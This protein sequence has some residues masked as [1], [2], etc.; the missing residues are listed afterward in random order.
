MYYVVRYRR[1][2][3]RENLI[4]S[5]PEKSTAEI[6][7]LEKKFYHHFADV[8]AEI[9][10][11]YRA[12]DMEEHMKYDGL[13]YLQEV[14]MAHNGAFVML[15]HLGCWEW[16]C[17]LGRRFD[18][19]NLTQYNVY[20]KLSNPSA[21]KAMLRLRAKR[22]GGMVEKQ[23]MLRRVIKFKRDHEYFVLGI[24]SD[25]KPSP[26]SSHFFTTFLN[27]ETA[28]LDGT[29]VLAKKFDYPVLYGRIIQNSRGHYTMKFEEIA[30]NPANTSEGEIT[31]IFA[32]KLEENIITQ[33]EM[34]LWTHN[35]WKWT[36]NPKKQ[37]EM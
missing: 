7:Q 3:V 5:F 34:W 2:V 18:Y 21:D 24:L 26:N 37:D 6:I 27:Q 32:E 1:H 15:A 35:R 25:Q 23:Q 10:H 31:R 29:E 28:F 33:P 12:D 17:D 4:Y 22:G 14:A 9:I 8:I 19:P 30:L 11:G 36:R 20:R 13:D 16:M